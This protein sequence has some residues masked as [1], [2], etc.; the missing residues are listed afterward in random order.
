MFWLES[1]GED[2]GFRNN[3]Y[4]LAIRCGYS[5]GFQSSLNV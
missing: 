5:Q 2:G 4:I 3:Q 1:D